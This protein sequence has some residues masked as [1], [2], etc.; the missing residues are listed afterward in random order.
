M[1]KKK[2]DP[3]SVGLCDM[4]SSMFRALLGLK[5]TGKEEVIVFKDHLS[6]DVLLSDAIYIFLMNFFPKAPYFLVEAFQGER[7]VH[8]LA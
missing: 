2:R 3:S 1:D 5:M 8:F 7:T 6:D 4:L